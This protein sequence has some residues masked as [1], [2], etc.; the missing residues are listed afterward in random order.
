MYEVHSDTTL[1]EA[2][3]DCRAN[4]EAAPLQD[5]RAPS[6]HKRPRW[7]AGGGRAPHPSLRGFPLGNG[8]V[9]AVVPSR[10]QI[11][12]LSSAAWELLRAPALPDYASSPEAARALEAMAQLGLLM[13]ATPTPHPADPTILT[14]WLHVTDACNLDCA[15]CYLQKS[16]EAMSEGV[17]Y[18]AV[19]AVFRSALANGYEG[20]ALKFAGG[21]ASLNMPLVERLLKHARALAQ[22]EGLTLAAGMLSNGLALTDDRL[23]LVRDLGL[24]LM[25]SL[26][27]LDAASD[28]QRL[29]LG[30][31]PSASAVRRRIERALALGVQ[32]DVAVTVTGSSVA[33]L[34]R[35]AEWMLGLDLPFSISFYRES[36]CGAARAE[37]QLDEGRLIE[38]L[39]ATYAVV[40]A[41][42]PRWSVLAA[43]LDRADLSAPHRRPCAAG[44]SYLVVDH[45]GRIAK[46]Q[47]ELERPVTTTA[48]PDPLALVRADT[49]SLQ[50]LPVE[51]KEGCRDCDWR[52]WCA[53]GC[54]IATYRATGRYDVRSPNC[55]IY[56]ALYPDLVRLE[57]TRI[58]F[59]SQRRA[60]P[61]ESPQ[62]A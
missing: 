5:C 50:N 24:R 44:H 32:P 3:H 59:W 40:A 19:E 47:M 49:I 27:G 37:L 7:P 41:R 48:A 60:L 29:T 1:F 33:G 20:V 14:A 56:Q 25:I 23:R 31:R 42:P 46:C 62:Q 9:A 13:E 11:V 10:S 51:E 34:P 53:G 8:Y 2:L 61:R 4:W 36:H 6:R 58:L 21:E 55:S 57:A 16:G 22:R 35:L 18:A 45:H 28:R 15:Y 30:G 39:R 26:D 17:G 43:L 54:P 38:G 12:V 52:W